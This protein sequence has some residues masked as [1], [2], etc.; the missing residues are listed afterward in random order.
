MNVKSLKSKMV[1]Q[2]GSPNIF[3]CFTSYYVHFISV[4]LDSIKLIN[5]FRLLAEKS[6]HAGGPL[7]WWAKASGEDS[8]LG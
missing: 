4:R 5:I 6:I 7:C 8:A 2:E 1:L 3:H